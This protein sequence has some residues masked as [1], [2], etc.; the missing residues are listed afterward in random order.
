M[1]DQYIRKIGLFV[2]NDQ[3]DAIDLSRMQ[4]VFETQQADVSTPN[5]AKIRVFNLSESTSRLVRTEFQR[6][7]LQAGYENGNYGTIFDG[8]I[9][10]FR[11]GR[12]DARDSFLDIMAGDGD[13][14]FQFALVN[15]TLAAGAT[16]QD[17]MNVVAESM[18]RYDVTYDASGNPVPGTGGVLPRGKVMFG[19]AKDQMSSIVDTGDATWSIQNGQLVVIPMTGYLPGEAVVLNSGTGMIGVPEATENGVEVDTLLNPRIRVGSRVQIDQATINQTKVNQQG[20][21]RYT[22]INFFASVARDGFYRVLVAEHR[23]DT[24]GPLWTTSLTCLSVNQSS[25]PDNSV[26]PYGIPEE[27]S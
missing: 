26:L 10:R 15:K 6:V 17:K 19:L 24:R 3:G 22:D 16:Q 18:S 13:K 12:L 5:I 25:P 20:F 9:G 14:A 21:P 11:F 27:V 4:I 23:G 8:Q 1:S 7:R 2:S